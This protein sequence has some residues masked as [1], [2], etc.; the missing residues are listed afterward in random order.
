MKSGRKTYIIAGILFIGF[1]LLAV[2]LRSAGDTTHVR[3]LDEIIESG[4]LHI[5]SENSSM[6]IN[7]GE[8]QNSGFQYEILKIFADTLGVEL[9]IS[10]ANDLA[11][12]ID[13]LNKGKYDLIARFIPTTTE[14]IDTVLF[15]IPLLTSR[16][17]LV[18]RSFNKGK[19]IR[20]NHQYELA[21]DS[22]YIQT[23]SPH[24][25]R[26]THLSKEIA[27]TIYIVELENLTAEQLVA[28]VAEGKIRNTICHE[29]LSR[30]LTKEYSNID[31]SIPVSL[32]QPYSWAVNKESTDLLEKLNG[33]LAAF[34]GSSDY[35]N[36]YRKYY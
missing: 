32:S 11:L 29:Q 3:S 1:I 26:L 27:D 28:L 7:I 5:V 22:I 35:W 19:E 15:S 17:M 8:G 36:L 12:S 31:A 30:K 4:K 24:K 9:K 25:M 14:W 21:G 18:Q 23:N 10:T 16:Q 6:G 34:I 13:L 20:I 2:L 33:F